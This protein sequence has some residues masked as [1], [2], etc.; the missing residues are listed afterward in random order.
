MHLLAQLPNGSSMIGIHGSAVKQWNLSGQEITSFIGHSASVSSVSFSPD[1]YSV[2]TASFDNTAKLWDISGRVLQTLIG[3]IG[4][5]YS[6]AFSP[7]QS[8]ILTGS[9]D[10][11][12][13]LWNVQN[14]RLAATFYSFTFGRGWAVT[15]PDGRFDGDEAGLRNL[16]YVVGLEAIPLDRLRDRTGVFVI[17]GSANDQASYEASPYGMGLLTYSLLLG[18]TGGALQEG[19]IVDVESLFKFAE[20]NVPVLAEDVG[21]IQ[22]PKFWKPEGSRSF[23]IGRVTE[24]EQRQLALPSPKPVF[25]RASFFNP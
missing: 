20:E 22:V 1:G 8:W 12:A 11:T 3:H 7:N 2:L 23:P 21:A 6:T 15:T 5:V 13:K 9:L 17:S 19:E 18:M 14:G 16:H 24:A 25:A 4:P 10:G